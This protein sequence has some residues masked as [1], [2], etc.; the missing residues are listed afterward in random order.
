LIFFDFD[1]IKILPFPSVVFIG[2]GDAAELSD[3]PGTESP[4]DAGAAKSGYF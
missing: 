1:G 4:E 3:A 2:N